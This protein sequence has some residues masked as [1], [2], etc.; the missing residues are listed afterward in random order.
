MKELYNY[1][2]HYIRAENIVDEFWLVLNH[3]SIICRKLEPTCNLHSTKGMFPV[4]SL[5]NTTHKI[6]IFS[7]FS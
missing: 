1:N 3:A 4:K 5:F 2:G 6:E 7:V